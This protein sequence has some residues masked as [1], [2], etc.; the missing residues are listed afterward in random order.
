MSGMGHASCCPRLV[1]VCNRARSMSSLCTCVAST[2]TTCRS[3]GRMGPFSSEFS[4]CGGNGCALATRR[5]LKLSLFRGGKLYTRYRVL[6]Q[7]I[8]THHALF[9]SR[10]CSGLN[11]PGGPRGPRC[12][13]PRRCFLLAPSSVSLKLKTVIQGI[14][15]GKG[16]HMPALHGIRLATPC[17]RGKCFGALR[18]VMR[19]CGMHSMDSRFPPTRCPT[20]IGGSRLNGLKLAPRRRTT[21]ITFVGALASKCSRRGSGPARR[22][23]S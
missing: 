23:G 22:R 18:R 15:R 1:H 20:A 11:V 4:T 19:F 2:L 6:R 9:A 16:F 3:S 7:S 14:R 17:K 5:G 13:I 10:A 21:L 8:V 12:Y